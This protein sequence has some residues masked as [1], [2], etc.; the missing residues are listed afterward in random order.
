MEQIRCVAIDDEH[1]AIRVIEKYISRIERCNLIRKFTNP[2]E[3]MEWMKENPFHVLF[4]DISMPQVTGIEILKK[5]SNPPV[6]IFTTAYSEF[7]ADAFDLDAADYL[8]KPFSFDRFKRAISKA[9]DIIQFKSI[10]SRNIL[11]EDK[12]YENQ[13]MLTIKC[14][15]KK[16]KVY[17]KN[18][19]YIQAYQEY[20][21]IYTS[22]NKY[23]IYERMKNVEKILP[24]PRFFR[25]HRSYIVS[26]EKVRSYSGN[27]LEVEGF[28]I[29]VSRSCKDELLRHIL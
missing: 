28:E 5:L 26:L 10:L 24:F 8:L 16:L 13:E 23:V 17:L 29:P 27:L 20:I 7:A 2:I 11:S 12:S 22:S 19:I 15:G 3:A 4:L 1:P 18:I 6:I 9:E 25:V 14:D 21:C